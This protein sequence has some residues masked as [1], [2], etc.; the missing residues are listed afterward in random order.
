MKP[1]CQLRLVSLALACGAGAQHTTQ[2]GGISLYEIATPDVG[3]AAAGY[4]ARAEDASTVF[5]NPA[6]MSRLE[7]A[8]VGED[9]GAPVPPDYGP[10]G[11]AFNGEVR[12]V[13]LSIADDP[14]NSDHLIKPEDAIRA[15]LGRQ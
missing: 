7:G 11:N 9:S 2:A 4:A 12:G 14:N 13:L 5:T 8:D 6:G 10:V 3:L 1:R 15:A